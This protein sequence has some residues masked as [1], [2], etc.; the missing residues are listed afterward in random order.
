M[1]EIS[2][3]TGVEVAWQIAAGEA[4]AAKHPH[5]RTAHVL[6]GIFSFEKL[7]P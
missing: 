4:T 2:I 3:S 1:N 7:P 5:I 6:L